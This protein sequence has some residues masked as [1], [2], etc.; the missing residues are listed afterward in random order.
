VQVRAGVNN[1]A[2][3]KTTNSFFDVMYSDTLAP[4]IIG[5]DSR[6]GRDAN[7]LPIDV[8]EF[9][10]DGTDPDVNALRAWANT[11]IYSFAWPTSETD[12]AVAAFL[13]LQI[14]GFADRYILE[15][16]TQVERGGYETPFVTYTYAAKNVVNNFSNMNR[17]AVEVTLRIGGP[18]LVPGAN[19][20]VP[21][22]GAVLVNY[23]DP[24]V[25]WRM[26][27]TTTF[28]NLKRP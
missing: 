17:D 23:S 6:G 24:G 21:I 28:G 8:R 20:N 22:T 15:S 19:A 2:L 4:S 18:D 11:N 9:T 14:P 27:N 10:D 16:R 3:A 1:V 26:I 5:M 12:A 13:A 25:V 7:G